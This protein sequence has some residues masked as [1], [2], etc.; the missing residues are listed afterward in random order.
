[1]RLRL[2]IIATVSSLALVAFGSL[3]VSVNSSETGKIAQP[4]AGHPLD[5]IIS[6]YNYRTPE[7]QSLQDDDFENPGF[8][9]VEKGEELWS[10]VDG[11]AGKSCESCHEDA[12]ETLKT[13]GAHFP[14]WNDDLGK[15]INLEQQINKCRTD[16]MQAKAWKWES[17]ELL[18]MTAYTRMQ[19]RGE[20]V[21]VE[22][23]GKM[24]P[25]FEQGKD[26]YYTRV[27]QLDMACSNCHE[28]N[29]GNQ[30]RSDLLSQG[31]TNGFPT[32]R[33]KW[34]K[35][36]STHRRF[37]GCMKNIRATPY[38]VGSDEFVNLELYI[39]Y[40]GQGLKVEAPAVRN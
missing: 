40:R 10:A 39:A 7:T 12:S 13:A 19:S 6:G 15:P 16:Q 30:I 28:D 37:K 29:Y 4:P 8:I 26:L 22:I 36:G 2:K 21:K 24:K 38:A 3:A 9:W 27:G 18:A 17:E 14:K 23:D 25:F 20:P 35:L 11:A 5:E 32:Y 33:L 31:Q 34:Q 1:M